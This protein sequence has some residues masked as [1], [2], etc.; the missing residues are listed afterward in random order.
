MTLTQVSIDNKEPTEPS[1]HCF[2]L[3]LGPTRV[4]DTIPTNE[5]HQ[6]TSSDVFLTAKISAKHFYS[7]YCNTNNQ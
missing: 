6:F 1:L 4:S 3:Q 2:S 5:F 7:Y